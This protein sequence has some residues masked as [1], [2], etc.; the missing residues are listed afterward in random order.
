[1]GN[2]WSSRCWWNTHH[3]QPL[4]KLAGDEEVGVQPYLESG[5]FSIPGLKAKAVIS[6]LWPSAEAAWH[7]IHVIGL[8]GSLST[9]S[10]S[11]CLQTEDATNILSSLN[12]GMELICGGQERGLHMAWSV[13]SSGYESKNYGERMREGEM[14]KCA[15]CWKTCSSTSLK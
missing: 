15:P 3:P 7:L 2:L 1:M 12:P 14:C 11:N 9:F 4:A 13:G 5:R 6:C 8:G 10:C